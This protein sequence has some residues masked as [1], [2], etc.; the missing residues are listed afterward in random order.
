[1]ATDT[2]DAHY[3]ANFRPVYQFIYYRVQHRETAEDL[4]TTAFLKALERFDSFDE[5]KASFRTW[6]FSIA[7]NAIV[8]HWRKTRPHED[9]EDIWEALKADG[10]MA[11][12]TDAK[13]RLEKVRAAMTA[14]TPEQREVV[15]LRVWDGLSH[16][17]IAATL[18][19]SED[20]VKMAFS[21][22][23]HELRKHAPLALLTL[24]LLK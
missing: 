1:M 11:R 15:I 18:G 16:A 13:M 2:F 10:D 8:D 17:E 7:R 20:A 21:R 23:V 14:L 9:V 3:K 12:D 4:T 22:A 5:A 19:K 6:I 24:F